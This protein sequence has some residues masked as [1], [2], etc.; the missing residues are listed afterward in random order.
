MRKRALEEEIASLNRELRTVYNDVNGLRRTQAAIEEA[1][2][3]LRADL[4]GL[5]AAALEREGRLVDQ[6]QHRHY[7]QLDR[8][9]ASVAAQQQL[10]GALDQ[11]LVSTAPAQ[12]V[13]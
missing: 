7:Q 3:Q 2:R 4:A 1:L 11:L 5:E 10:V 12:D 9:R 13:V 6:L 8:L